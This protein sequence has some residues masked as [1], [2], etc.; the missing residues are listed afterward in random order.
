MVV[1]D[2]YRGDGQ[3]SSVSGHTTITAPIDYD[4]MSRVS[5]GPASSIVTPP[6]VVTN[7]HHSGPTAGGAGPAASTQEELPSTIT[8]AGA[9][10]SPGA[11]G[12]TSNASSLVQNKNGN[13]LPLATGTG[14]IADTSPQASH[15]STHSL[16][17]YHSGQDTFNEQ[18]PP[19]LVDGASTPPT[20]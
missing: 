3:G 8:A 1:D 11:G 13:K 20:P 4:R 15:A 5:P 18:T 9:Q 2:V 19:T 12:G 17:G 14:P 6:P 7:S 16:R 10:A